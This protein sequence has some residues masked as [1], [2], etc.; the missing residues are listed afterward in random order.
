MRGDGVGVGDV[1]EVPCGPRGKRLPQGEPDS[2]FS[3]EECIAR[4]VV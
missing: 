2:R 3:M 1:G 4:L